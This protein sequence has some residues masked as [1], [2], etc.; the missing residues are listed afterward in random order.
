MKNI[1]LAVSL[2]T[3]FS[4]QTK[5][6][7]IDFTG[8]VKA[9]NE[10]ANPWV[11][12][13]QGPDRYQSFMWGT[14]DLSTST[15]EA[16]NTFTSVN[17]ASSLSWNFS[18]MQLTNFQSPLVATAGFEEYTP[19]PNHA[20]DFYSGG[21]VVATGSVSLFRVDVDN[22]NDLTAIGSGNAVLLTN[23]DG[24]N[25]FFTEVLNDTGG[26]MELLF[27]V[28]GFFPVDYVGNFN[29]TGTLSTVPEPS[30]AALAGLG[31]LGLG[32]LALLRRR[33]TTES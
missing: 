23:G 26:S 6:S 25:A 21:A 31:A 24:P 7:T 32:A 30:T 4:V 5:A 3:A 11:L 17:P 14:I 1:L 13:P 22:I 27:T 8:T 9:D 20:L 29:S 15:G 28:S 18:D 19:G 16:P 33:R 12:Y 2:I 10:T